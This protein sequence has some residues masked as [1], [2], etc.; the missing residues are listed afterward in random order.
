MPVNTYLKPVYYFIVFISC[1]VIALSLLSLI[2][3]LNLWMAKVLDF[4]R[5][6]YFTVAVICL[7]LLLFLKKTWSKGFI[8]LLIGLSSAIIIQ[9]V[10]IAP[11]LVGE[12]QVPNFDRAQEAQ[13]R[14]VGILIA[15][16]LMT[17]RQAADLLQ[18]IKEKDPEMVLVMEVNE[19][20]INEL[21]SL[22]EDFPYTVKHPLDNAYG[23]ALYSKFPLH[24][25]EIL[26][27]N[28]DK[29][30][31]IHTEVELTSG[32]KFKFHGVHPVAP[33]PSEKYPDN[34]GKEE[35]ALLKVG[36][37]VAADSLPSIVAGDYNDV[38]WSHTSRLFGKEGDLRNVRLGRGL[39]NSFD[40]QSYILR[41]P[42]DHYFVT[43]E[44]SLTEIVRLPEFGSDHFPLFAEFVLPEK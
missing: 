36:R 31:S 16:V 27:F 39:Y 4:P 8:F 3:D 13:G 29:V 43:E 22:E 15:N 18:I 26:F 38:S 17:N 6:Q 7:I 34:M 41:W 25:Q 30:P 21:G 2:Y 37:M 23:M 24:H 42:L 32:E 12:K 14:S 35:V 5:L 1:A 33:V 20:W 19:W 44:F 9:G 40:A 10:R 11:Y 28:N